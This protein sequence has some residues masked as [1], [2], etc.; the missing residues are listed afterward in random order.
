MKKTY[1][2]NG[3]TCANCANRIEQSIKEQDNVKQVNLDFMNQKLNVEGDIALIDLQKLV[4][5]I[6]EGVVLSHKEEKQKV[7]QTIRLFRIFITTLLLIIAILLKHP[8]FSLIIYIC[9]Y[10]IVAYDILISA[11][12]K[13]GK[14]NMFDEKFLMSV[15]TIGA[16][17]IKESKE[18]VLVMLLYQVGEYFQDLAV[19]KSRKSIAKTMNIRPQFARVKQGSTW[20]KVDPK[21][22]KIDDLI[23]VL[24]GEC[25]PIDG[26][27]VK[28]ISLVDLSNLTGESIP[29]QVNE[30]DDVF[31]GSVNLESPIIVRVTT[32]YQDSTVS[33][34]LDL[35]EQASNK[36]SKSE[37]L[38]T[39]FAKVYTP[40]VVLAAAIIALIVPII[41]GQS[42]EEWVYR[43][44]I[45]LVIS[46][47]CALVISVPITFYAGVGGI[48]SQGALIK[49]SQY[50][51]TLSSIDTLVFDKTGTLTVGQF[52]VTGITSNQCY[53]NQDVLYYASLANYH[54]NHP[55]A[56]AIIKAYGQEID[57]SIIKEHKSIH[58]LGVSA[59]I[60]QGHVLVG[61]QQLIENHGI[62]VKPNP[63]VHTCVFVAKDNEL[64]GVIELSDV[65]K[66]TTKEAIIDLK[67]LGIKNMMIFSGDQ[68]AVVNQIAYSI[69]IDKAYG[70]LLPTQKV[71]LF[72]QLKDKG[73]KIGFVGDGIND[74]PVLMQSDV[75]IAM[76]G[77]GQDAA[78]EAADLVLMSDDL[79]QLVVAIKG[80]KKTV[81]IAKQ[82]IIFSIGIKAI[83]LVLSIFGL[84]SM[85]FALFAD[86]G[87]SLLA[88]ANA[89]RAR[90]IK[91]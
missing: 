53:T 32:T 8:T 20:K 62:K 67:K 60:D 48:A 69:G 46:C 61:N 90:H 51:E 87:V 9:A 11:I 30:H 18:A 76:G 64:I 10:L 80:A 3:L 35:V 25:I 19:E 45:F 47:P 28:G 77:I 81:S 57:S 29:K 71:Q 16:L 39:A 37:K 68:Q 22:V 56:K 75:G 72:E 78:I 66:D 88:T 13:I 91:R 17:I 15:A 44:L 6:E 82:N 12:K 40:I 63:S 23:E 27:I 31:S 34:I 74:A 24:P 89:T 1:Y 41:L 26:Q 7:R 2:I 54:A 33:K 84:V 14:Q 43:A 73:H 65:L 4:D 5:Q 21:T 52:F 70:H 59:S 58:G 79:L 85:W 49:G 83:F 55:I 86:V 38:I 36:K 42:F 50:V